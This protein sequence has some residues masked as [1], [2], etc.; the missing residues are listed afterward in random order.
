[1]QPTMSDVIIIKSRPSVDSI[2]SMRFGNEIQ[3]VD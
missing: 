2:P 3:S 1:M